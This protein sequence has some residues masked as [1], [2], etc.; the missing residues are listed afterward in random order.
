MGGSGDVSDHDYCYNPAAESVALTNIGKN[1]CTKGN[2]CDKCKGD[3]D[4][5]SHCK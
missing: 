3:C 5:D 4:K 1:G 2:P